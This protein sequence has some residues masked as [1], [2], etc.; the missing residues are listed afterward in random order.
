M[1]MIHKLLTNLAYTKL[2]SLITTYCMKKE[3][4]NLFLKILRLLELSIQTFL[5][6]SVK[7]FNEWISIILLEKNR[8]NHSSN[9]NLTKCRWLHLTFK[10]GN[11]Y[12]FVHDS[13]ML[14]LA[15]DIIYRFVLK[16]ITGG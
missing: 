7:I 15:L 16:H 2:N 10:N 1:A 12:N 3:L 11:A 8:A 14:N 13:G 5:N 6:F 9:V 4:G